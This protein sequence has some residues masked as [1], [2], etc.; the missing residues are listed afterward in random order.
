MRVAR[1]FFSEAD[2]ASREKYASYQP[3]VVRRRAAWAPRAGRMLMP[4]ALLA[5]GACA[6]PVIPDSLTRPADPDAPVPSPAYHSVTAGAA[7]LRPSG[8]M[9]WREINRRVTPQK[10]SAT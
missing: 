5:L 9:N 3:P 1:A 10:G 2:A 7:T 8:P 6:A 4:V